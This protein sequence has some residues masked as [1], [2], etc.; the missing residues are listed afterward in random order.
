MNI[1]NN[2]IKAVK[3]PRLILAAILR[4]C[5]HWIKDDKWYV[6]TRYYLYTGSK[7]NL[8]NPQT[9][10][11]KLCWQKLYDHNP[12][13]TVM[14]DKYAAKDYVASII[15]EDYII[16]TI[17]VWDSPDNIEWEKLPNQF[18]LK[19]THDSGGVIVV[20]DKRNLDK[21]AAVK[22]LKSCLKADN[23]AS[24]REWPYKNV[25]RRV[26]AETYMEDEKTG[27]L[28]D[29]KFFSFDG[30]VRA[31]F[32]SQDRGKVGED[33]KFDYFDA[34]YNH[35]PISQYHEH[36]RTTPAK[37]SCFEEMKDLASKLSKGIPQVRVDFY[38]VDGKVYFGE[39]TFF[40][41]GGI[42]PFYPEEMELYFWFW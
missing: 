17:G 18:V 37:P 28:R 9:Y 29:Y 3:Y 22:K 26:I 34:D 4:D 2:F 14:V 12:L 27:E 6:T 5:A 10:N 16:P 21:I 15:G 32:V 33:V 42:V 39:L 23:Y 30:V 19:T 8:N 11:E 24:T 38:E 35:L 7:L 20:K 36:G 40:H 25:P 1:K 31:M 41:H 13:Y